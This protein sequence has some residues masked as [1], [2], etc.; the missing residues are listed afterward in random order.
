MG[1][2]AARL[3]GGQDAQSKRGSFDVRLVVDGEAFVYVQGSTIRYENVSG[4]APANEGSEYSQ[5]LPR[6]NFTKFTLSKRDGRGD[7]EL[8]EPPSEA[9]DYTAKLRIS[10]PRGGDDHYHV[11]LEWEWDVLAEPAPRPTG[12]LSRHMEGFG[13]TGNASIVPG[14]ATPRGANTPKGT[15]L[16]STANDPSDYS[17][18]SSGAFEFRGRIDGT[19]ILRIQGDRVFAENTSGRPVELERF[20]F[21][22]P[23]PSSR[24]AKIELDK[25]NG[26]GQAVLLERPWEENG[27][28]AVIQISDPSGGDDNYHLVLRWEK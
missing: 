12:I 26:R 10:D 17:T 22:Q 5:E 1:E 13:G 24:L 18:T 20:A 7:V 25:R 11:R 9:N 28:L 27:F 2:F 23:L 8:L 3:S 4:R 19:V 21:S 16:Q 14:T 6:A 15:E